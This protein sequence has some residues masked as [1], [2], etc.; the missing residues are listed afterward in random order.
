MD[1]D[2]KLTKDEKKALRKLEWQE[3]AKTEARDAKIK[4]LTI[5]G[6]VILVVLVVVFVLF[7][8][9]TASTST[10][11]IKIAPV[12]ARDIKEGNPKAKVTLIEYAD[13]QCPSCA[14][15]HPI[16]TQLLK[17][18]SNKIYYVY[19]MFPLEQAHPN[20]LASSEAA[21]AAYQQGAFFQYDDMLF[22]KQT[23]WSD[24]QD[25]STAFTDYATMLKLD[26]NKFKIDMTSAQTQKYVKDSENLALKEGVNYTPSFFINGN[27]IQNPNDYA[28]FKQLID[29]ELAKN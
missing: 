27:L 11:T 16:V 17:D 18:Y 19:R 23:E 20:A 22:N 6:G 13:F 7:Q 5:W 26:V 24:L 15:Y 25:P 28:G 3:K 1:E 4:K 9:V 10:P 2:H 21:Y 14:V 29:N 12:S 8:S